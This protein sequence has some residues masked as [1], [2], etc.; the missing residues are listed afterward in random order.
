MPDV[1]DPVC[2]M[3]LGPEKEAEALGAFVVVRGG[4]K[5]YLCSSTCKAQFEAR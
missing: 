4:K 2:G 1:L 3:D 5:H